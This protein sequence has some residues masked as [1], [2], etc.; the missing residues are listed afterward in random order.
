VLFL[1]NR[2]E[3]V[4]GRGPTD[5]ILGAGQGD[6]LL[7]FRVGAAVRDDSVDPA[8]QPRFYDLPDKTEAPRITRHFRFERGNGQWQINGRFMNCDRVRFRVKRN[9]SRGGCSRTARAGGSTRS[10]STSRSSS[11]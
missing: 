7:Q 11:S 1:E 5:R 3:Q 6:L 9:P 2:L 10:T 8:S 4:D